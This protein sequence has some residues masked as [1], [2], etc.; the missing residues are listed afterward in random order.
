MY[1]SRIT[2]WGSYS[3][4]R[5]LTNAELEGMVDTS[6]EWIVSRT[7]IRERHL[8]AADETTADMAVVACEKALAR[9]EIDASEIDLI[10]LATSTPD[11]LCPPSSSIIQ[12]RLGATRAG[13]MS[14]V[15]GCTGFVYGLVTATQFI[16]TGAYKNILVVGSE[17]LSYAIDWEDRN[18][19]VLFGD[20]AG[21]V[22]VSQSE[23]PGGMLSM[24]L[25][26]DGSD[27]DALIVPGIGSASELTNE[28]LARKEHKLRMDG[29]RV[30]KFAARTM[31]DSVTQVV[32][33][34]GMTLNDIQLVIPHQ[35]NQR[36]IDLAAKRLGIDQDKIVSN[37]ARYGN[38]SAASI[39]LALC[40]ALDDGRL[41]PGDRAVFVAFGAGLTNAACV[42]EFQ[43]EHVEEQPILVTNWPVSEAF[44]ERA[45]QMKAAAWRA[46][47]QART[48]ASDAAMSV[49]L[50]LY[51]F[52]KG[53][54]K[55]LQE[56]DLTQP[57]DES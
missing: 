2:G 5:I 37:I 52:R 10:I 26:S 29:Q 50:P 49:M 57:N 27:W 11:H 14:V 35:A 30:F 6:D 25:G 24:L 16:Q 18:T 22:V 53:V 32:V 36:I 41:K 40:E 9:A 1:H 48:M 7:G 4:A 45:L 19:C 23:Q 13:A 20:G 55:R 21:A 15:T 47:V 46:Q 51:T 43:P 38:T 39:P 3:P 56:L 34:A 28:A 12:H 31:I 54:K 44:R 42:W 8:A 33:D 17:K